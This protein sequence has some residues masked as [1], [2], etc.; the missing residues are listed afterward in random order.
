MTRFLSPNESNP[1]GASRDGESAYLAVGRLRKPHGIQG[2]I[3]MEVLTDFPERL[4]R[5]SKLLVGPEHITYQ[6]QALRWNNQ[7]MLLTFKGINTPEQAGELRNQMVYVRTADIPKLEEGE[8]YHHQLI[9]LQIYSDTGKLI[10]TV[11]ELIDAGS[12]DVLVIRPDLGKEILIPMVDEN[13][14]EINLDQGL[15]RMKLLPGLI[16]ED[17][18]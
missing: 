14:L 7:V 16:E 15:I 18:S 10:G 2:E 8:Y 11:R 12:T 6:I 1:A 17:E 13:I 4:K 3:S 9:G 5:G